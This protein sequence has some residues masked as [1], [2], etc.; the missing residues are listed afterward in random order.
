MDIASIIGLIACFGLM[1][2]GMVW[3]KDISTVMGFID[4]PSGLVTFGGS[5]MCILASYTIPDFM[6]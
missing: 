3:G 5:V 2:F 1:I 4:M 6:A